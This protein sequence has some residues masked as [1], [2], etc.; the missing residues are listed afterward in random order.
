M[1]GHHILAV[2]GSAG[3]VDTPA[4][5]LVFLLF[6]P[7]HAHTLTQKTS[8]INVTDNITSVIWST[9]DLLYYCLFIF[10]YIIYVIISLYYI[11]VLRQLFDFSHNQNRKQYTLNAI[12]VKC[13][14]H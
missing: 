9:K 5:Q 8:E 6:L 14:M 12:C 4:V 11:L 1:L 7:A 2:P 10:K 13:N 3:R